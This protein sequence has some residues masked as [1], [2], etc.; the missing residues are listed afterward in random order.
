MPQ[1]PNVAPT[2]RSIPEV[3]MTKV[4]P[5]AKKALIEMCLIIMIKLFGARKPSTMKE[6]NPKRINSAINVLNFNSIRKENVWTT[7][8]GNER[9]YR[10]AKKE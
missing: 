9:K 1:K 4:I 5:N 8:R 3:I 10:M 7:R 2:E 6:K